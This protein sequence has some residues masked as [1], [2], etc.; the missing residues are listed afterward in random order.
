MSALLLWRQSD[1]SAAE[2]VDEMAKLEQIDK[3]AERAKGGVVV[4]QSSR[5]VGVTLA[6]VGPLSRNERAAA[7][8]QT[9]KQ[10]DH[11]AASDAADHGE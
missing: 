7:V 5:S 11:T 2:S 1:G 4:W 9:E 6:P 3:T 8:G 10:K